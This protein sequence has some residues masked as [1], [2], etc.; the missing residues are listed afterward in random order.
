MLLHELLKIANENMP[1]LI[2]QKKTN[3]SFQ[4]EKLIHEKA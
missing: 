2:M 4:E 1:W 3:G